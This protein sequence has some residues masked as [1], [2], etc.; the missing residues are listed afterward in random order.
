MLH[1]QVIQDFIT[2]QFQAMAIRPHTHQV[3]TI[4]QAIRQ[5][6]IIQNRAIQQEVDI[7]EIIIIT[8]ITIIIMGILSE[9]AD[10]VGIPTLQIIIMETQNQMAGLDF[11]LLLYSAQVDLDQDLAIDLVLG[12]AQRPAEVLKVNK[13]QLRGHK[14]MMQGGVRQREVLTLKTE[15]QNRI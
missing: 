2:I 7:T 13:L 14:V 10:L 6:I 11:Y 8:A 15:S 3:L 4:H 9:A 5:E 1:P 12:I